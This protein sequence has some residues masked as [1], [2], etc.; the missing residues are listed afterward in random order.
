MSE[1]RELSFSEPDTVQPDRSKAVKLLD[2][3]DYSYSLSHFTFRHISEQ[4]WHT[5]RNSSVVLCVRPQPVRVRQGDNGQHRVGSYT[6]RENLPG[7]DLGILPLGRWLSLAQRPVEDVPIRFI[8]E[9]QFRNATVS[10]SV[11]DRGTIRVDSPYQT[12]SSVLHSSYPN[13]P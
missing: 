5:P 3:I 6:S 4:V 8:Q 11:F 13:A 12:A 1:Q 7:E 9:L 10:S 2:K